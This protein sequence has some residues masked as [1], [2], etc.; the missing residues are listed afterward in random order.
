MINDNID[1]A[2][3][4]HNGTK[5]PHGKLHSSF[6]FYDPA[7]RP[8]PYKIYTE[9]LQS[10]NLS[11]EK[12]PVGKGTFA[13]I[14][15]NIK[16]DDKTV[17][18]DLNTLSR[19]LYFSNGITKTIHYPRLGDMEFRAAACTG[20]LYHIEIYVVCGD[21]SGLGAGVYHFNPKEMSLKQLRKG[22]Y[23]HVLIGA[24]GNDE[25]VKHAPVIL[26]YTDIFTRNSI[27]Y[28][29]RE[30]R[31][32]FWDCGVI[33]TNTLALSSTHNL[34]AKVIVGFVDDA[35]NLLLDLNTQKEVSLA[36]VP[37]GFTK[38]IPAEKLQVQK[39]NLATEPLSSYNVDDPEIQVIHQ[40][41]SLA[42]EKDVIEWREKVIKTTLSLTKNDVALDFQVDKKILENPIESVII[43]RGS[44][45]EF[46]RQSIS[47]CQLSAIIYYSTRGIPAD[48]LKEGCSLV[49]LYLIVNSVDGLD[50]GA[51]Y[52]NKEQNSLQLLREGNLRSIAGHLGLDQSLPA[53][54]SVCVFFMSDLNEV[55]DKFGNRGYRASQLEAS[56]IGGRFYLASYAQGLGATG[57]TFYDDKVTQFFSPHAKNKSVMFL[58]A[59]GKKA[60][61]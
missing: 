36:L 50:S 55:L 42:T 5:H 33:L 45:R 47:F 58:V 10:V 28:Q 19:I 7:F 29:T 31:H 56:T 60:T 30:Y 24:S 20:A 1:A 48:F 4:Y 2:W 3:H 14:S 6:Y 13:A 26:V 41:S 23:R 18:P 59:I 9:N 37:I 35:V 16:Q 12:K 54:G 32:A 43:K 38:E 25:N 21:I 57:L 44:T 40:A 46:S 49:D 53:D 15:D 27:K 34:P 39:L 8:T 22:D 17:V 61:I 11:L 51:Y 52:Y